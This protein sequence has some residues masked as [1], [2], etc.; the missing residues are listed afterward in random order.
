MESVSFMPQLFYPKRKRWQYTVNI[1]WWMD[2]TSV[3][4]LR[5]GIAY[6]DDCSVGHAALSLVIMLPDVYW[7][8]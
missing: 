6:N 2:P 3:W 1:G 7:D 4:K 8:F 5:Q